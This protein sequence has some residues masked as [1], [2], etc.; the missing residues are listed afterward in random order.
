M[1]TFKEL[2]ISISKKLIGSKKTNQLNYFLV[3]GRLLNLDNP[4]TW[5]EKL[6]WLNYHWQP[7]IKADCTDK[8]KVREFIES[9]GYSDSLIPL[10]GK[11]N[12]ANEIDFDQLPNRFVL[13]CNHGCATN[14]IVEDKFKLDFDAA[15]KQLNFWLSI[16]YSKRADEI[17][18]GK[19]KPCIICEE[20]L[21]LLSRADVVDYKIHCF[22]GKPLFIA[23]NFERDPITL[24]P[25][26][27]VY[28][29]SWERI[30]C[31]K[32]DFKKR[33]K[34]KDKPIGLSKMLE[35]AKKLSEDFPYV[36]VDLY[37]IEDRVFFGELTFTPSGN[38]VDH[39]YRTEFVKQMGERLI[40][41]NV[42]I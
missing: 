14:I 6:F 19:I 37:C 22:N 12:N 38:C 35:M 33:D 40:L 29:P 34:D 13:K 24:H 36:R 15:R 9:K 28:S 11:W 41:P 16:D 1:N 10:L 26:S 17:H 27:A 5:S 31:L 42:T 7:Q 32:D 20:F 21:P 8:F 3:T 23:A 30:L 4:K 18:Y 39:D 25:H 2:L